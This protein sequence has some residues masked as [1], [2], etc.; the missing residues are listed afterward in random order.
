MWVNCFPELQQNKAEQS[1]RTWDLLIPTH[2]RPRHLGPPSCETAEGCHDTLTSHSSSWGAN[3]VRH[4]VLG[5][6]ESMGESPCHLDTEGR[7]GSQRLFTLPNWDT[8]VWSKEYRK[9]ERREW[10]E[11]ERR[12]EKDGGAEGAINSCPALSTLS[13]TVSPPSQALP[14]VKVLPAREL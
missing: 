11:A 8:V 5:R 12:R 13:L 7:R 3:E 10:R 2:K 4:G 14:W 1:P 6:S 9:E